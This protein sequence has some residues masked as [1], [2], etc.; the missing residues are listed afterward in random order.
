MVKNNP[1]P[2]HRERS[3]RLKHSYRREAELKGLT[4]RR[5]GRILRYN[6]VLEQNNLI[7]TPIK[8]VGFGYMSV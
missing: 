7:G 5:A 1:A 8:L 4:W 6:G 2:E 3:I